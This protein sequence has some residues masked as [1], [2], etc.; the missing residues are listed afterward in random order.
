MSVSSIILTVVCSG[1]IGILLAYRTYKKFADARMA[2]AIDRMQQLERY[3]MA[4]CTKEVIY[5]FVR[6]YSAE[7]LNEKRSPRLTVE[8]MPDGKTE[9]H[10]TDV[11]ACSE[12]HLLG[13]TYQLD[14]EGRLVFEKAPFKHGDILDRTPVTV[15]DAALKC[16]GMFDMT[17]LAE[18]N[19]DEGLLAQFVKTAFTHCR[20]CRKVL[21]PEALHT[22]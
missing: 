14:A 6:P 3:I 17:R 13:R 11:P 20:P 21:L 8:V 1:L 12:V 7:Y 4:Q 22:A 10:A 5:N 16:N 9:F 18:E 15:G 2:E 19:E